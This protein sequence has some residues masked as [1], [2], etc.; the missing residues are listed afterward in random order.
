MSVRKGY[1]YTDG[2]TVGG[3]YK[4]I[5]EAKDAASETQSPYISIRA[6]IEIEKLVDG[7]WHTVH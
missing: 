7:V 1:W 6:A 4:S 3:P 5:K 2:A